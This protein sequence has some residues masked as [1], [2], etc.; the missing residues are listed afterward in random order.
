MIDPPPSREHR[1][2]RV[3]QRQE[4]AREVDVDG[5]APHVEVEIA[6]LR[7][8]AEELHARVRDDDVG[9]PAV[10]RE[11]GEGGDDGCLVGDVHGHGARRVAMPLDRRLR[12]GVIAIGEGHASALL[13]EPQRHL[14]SDARGGAGHERGLSGEPFGHVR[15]LHAG[16]SSITG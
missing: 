15:G 13:Q 6:G 9:D 2:H 3:L 11:R 1:A 16:S 14:A 4:R 12:A 7:I 8:L 10:G 5:A